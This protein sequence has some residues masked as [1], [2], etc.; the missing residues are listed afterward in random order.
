MSR[1]DLNGRRFSPVRN[2]ATGR[3][4]SESVFEYQQTGDEFTAVYYGEGFTDGHLIGCFTSSDKAD[5]IY[6]CRGPKGELEIG[7]A[8]ASFSR[9]DT[10]KIVIKMDWRWLNL[11]QES[12]TSEYEEVHA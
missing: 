3:V 10:G 7:E 8:K 4:T 2:S 12:G 11:T 9:N 1:F 6:H 5:L